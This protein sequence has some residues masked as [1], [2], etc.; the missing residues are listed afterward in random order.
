MEQINLDRNHLKAY[1]EGDDGELNG[2]I[3]G[4]IR[5]HQPDSLLQ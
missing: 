5:H 2:F 1:Q 3:N 4:E